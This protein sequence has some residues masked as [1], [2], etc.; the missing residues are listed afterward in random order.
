VGKLAEDDR[1]VSGHLSPAYRAMI[2]GPEWAAWRAGWWARHPNARCTVCGAPRR[3][4]QWPRGLRWLGWTD[5]NH[6]VYHS[7][8]VVDPATGRPLTDPATGRPHMTVA[9]PQHDW[10]VAPACHRPCHLWIITPVSRWMHNRWRGYVAVAAGFLAG[11]PVRVLRLV[12]VLWLLLCCLL[13]SRPARR[14]W[15][16]R[17]R[18]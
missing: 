14:R 7:V 9:L 4:R 13:G 8:P 16:R 3:L 5:L 1:P 15:R 17:Y 11:L 12:F 2:G 18:R 10:E 6:L